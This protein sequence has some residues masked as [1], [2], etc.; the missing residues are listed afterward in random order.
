MDPYGKNN[1]AQYVPDEFDTGYISDASSTSIE[2]ESESEGPYAPP[3]PDT[4][5]TSF[6]PPGT[7][8]PSPDTVLTSFTPPGTPPRTPPRTPPCTENPQAV[9]TCI[10][11]LENANKK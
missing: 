2:Y 8:P 4:V 3:S 5:L 11:I 9:T 6:T 1:L 7:P 10:R